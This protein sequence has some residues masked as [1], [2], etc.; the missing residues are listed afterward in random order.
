MKNNWDGP[1]YTN[2]TLCHSSG[3]WKHHKY[4]QKIGEG[5]NAIYKYH[6]TGEGYKEEA[7]KAAEESEEYLKKSSKAAKEGYNSTLKSI[8]YR[9]AART[10]AE[11]GRYDK[12]HYSSYPKLAAKDAKDFLRYSNKKQDADRASEYNSHMH[13]IYSDRS[14]RAKDKEAKA[15]NDYKTKS[16]AGIA[17]A[18]IEKG[19]NF[20]SKLFKH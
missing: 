9:D 17:E 11:N 6:V 8:E 3:P 20:I 19:K 1:Q 12:Q 13:Q 7:A 18:T 14:D 15:N 4:I 10:A 16:L 5:A 2:D